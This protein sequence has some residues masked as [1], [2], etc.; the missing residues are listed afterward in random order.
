MTT[1]QIGS[2]NVPCGVCVCPWCVAVCPAE[3]R[4]RELTEQFLAKCRSQDERERALQAARDQV[5][6]LDRAQSHIHK[7][8]KSML[9][10]F[11]TITHPR[12]THAALPL[13]NYG[14]RTGRGWG[15]VRVWGEADAVIGQHAVGRAEDGWGLG[16][17]C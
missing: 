6:S 1:R 4:E 3:A 15:F 7:H 9:P 13:H 10:W 8:V 2:G 12:E 5:R 11:G 14:V 16:F 17:C